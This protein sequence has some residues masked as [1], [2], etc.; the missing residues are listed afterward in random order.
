[1]LTFDELAKLVISLI[2]RLNRI[3][4]IVMNDRT[5]HKAAEEPMADAIAILGKAVEELK[6]RLPDA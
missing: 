3:E 1:M 6:G 4:A 5:A 2:D